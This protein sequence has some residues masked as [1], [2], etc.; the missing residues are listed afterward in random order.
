MPRSIPN[1]LMFDGV[2]EQAIHFYRSIFTG[3][4]VRVM[5]RWRENESGRLGAVKRARFSIG[6]EEIIVLDYVKDD[7]IFAPSKSLFVEC[8]SAAEL[9]ALYEGLSE[10]GERVMPLGDYGFSKLF[11]A[12]TDRFGLSWQLSWS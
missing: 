6:S 7:F 10:G 1:F 4:E 2:A 11:G 5:E 12:V 3:S 8:E 9:D